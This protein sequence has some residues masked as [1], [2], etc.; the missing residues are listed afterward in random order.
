MNI[1]TAIVISAFFLALSPALY[2]LAEL[3][4]E[5]VKLKRMDVED[6]LDNICKEL[7]LRYVDVRGVERVLE[8]KIELHAARFRDIDSRFEI[9]EEKHI[10]LNNRVVAGGRKVS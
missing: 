10:K 3:A 9:L 1:S 4:S 8:G 2:K 5:W 7:N 6:R